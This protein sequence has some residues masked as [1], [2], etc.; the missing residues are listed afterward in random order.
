MFPDLFP[1]TR[2]LY[3]TGMI[4]A[5]LQWN[6]PLGRLFYGGELKKFDQKIKMQGIK[7]DQLQAQINTEIT[8]ARQQLLI[9]RE[10]IQIAKEALSLSIEALNQSI[11]RQKLGTARPFE[12]FQAQQLFLQGQLDYFAAVASYNKAQFGLKVAEGKQL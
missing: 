1:E 2:Q 4:N 12:V 11:E 8:N 5:S 9:G 3:P 6:I 10:Q 7:S